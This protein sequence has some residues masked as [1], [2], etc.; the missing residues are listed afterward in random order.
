[1]NR[2]NRFQEHPERFLKPLEGRVPPNDLDAEGAVLSAVLLDDVALDECAELLRPEHFY[3]D[4]NRWVFE[5]ALEVQRQDL[6]V[7]LI[8]VAKSLKDQ[9]RLDQVGGTPYLHQIANATPAV[10][11]LSSH[12]RLVFDKWRQRNIIRLCWEYATKGY[13]TANAG[14]YAEEVEAEIYRAAS[15]SPQEQP[16]AF[17]AEVSREVLDY[18]QKASQSPDWAGARTG[19]K[20]LDAQIIGLGRGDLWLVA[21]RPGSGKTTWVTQVAEYRAECGDL[22]LFFSLEMKRAQLGLRSASR[23]AH[24]RLR[25]L[26]QG[27]VKSSEW[28]NFTQALADMGEL[29]L[30]VDDEPMLTPTKLRSKIR[31]HVAGAKQKF[32]NANLA[33]V[34]I[35]YLQLMHPDRER[36]T[37]NDEVSEISRSL[38]LMAQMFDVPVVAL[39]QL[40][41]PAKGKAKE[42]PQ[43]SDLR[44]SGAL[45]QD[46]DGVIMIHRPDQYVDDEASKTGQAD[47]Y[48]RKGRNCGDGRR[49]TIGFD[50]RYTEFT[51]IEGF[52]EPED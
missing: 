10:A 13:E 17:M 26:R 24:V 3:S 4:A 43:L 33:M 37:T 20:S 29:P 8:T 11:H 14:A 42:P 52:D 28:M 7:D 40:S 25:N 50:G 19:F 5:A 15:N 9:G 23:R 2:V 22:V 30:I 31:R 27:K 6:H 48:V 21:G 39:S 35:D 38:K 16:A 1:M 45:E 49:H 34:V 32:P 36:G 47:L 51:D 41:R 46:A 18:V 44:D 12:A